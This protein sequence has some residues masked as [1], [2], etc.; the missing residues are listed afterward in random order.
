MSSRSRLSLVAGVVLVVAGCAA[1]AQSAPP[2]AEPVPAR[3]DTTD[4]KRF[5]LPLDAYAPSR[6]E[7][8]AVGKA[9]FAAFKNCMLG[10]GFDIGQLPE[11]P[12]ETAGVNEFRYGLTDEVKARASGY[13]AAPPPKPPQPD[14]PPE[15]RPIASGKGERTYKDKPVPEGGCQGEAGRKVAEGAA[16]DERLVLRLGDEA[17]KQAEA[18]SRVK[19]A[20]QAWS[21]CMAR[22]GFDYAD[23]WKPNDNPEFQGQ[24]AGAREIATATADV[25]CKREVDLVGV[26]ASVEAAYQERK[27]GENAEALKKVKEAIRTM[28]GNAARITGAK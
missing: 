13:T 20:F 25:R 23:P 10:F 19:A 11:I 22:A 21:A 16:H 1:T 2:P 24:E 15:G 9:R 7:N 5:A 18:D 14:I 27:I 28:L 6:A 4:L 26:W 8:T 12:P 17:G 3:V